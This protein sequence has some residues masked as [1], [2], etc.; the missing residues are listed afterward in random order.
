LRD[1]SFFQHSALTLFFFSFRDE[2]IRKSDSSYRYLTLMISL[3]NLEINLAHGERMTGYPRTENWLVTSG[4]RCEDSHAKK[5]KLDAEFV[6]VLFTR[7]GSVE[8]LHAVIKE[9]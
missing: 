7:A 6:L 4:E 1:V 2:N 8:T 3:V 9:V 5:C